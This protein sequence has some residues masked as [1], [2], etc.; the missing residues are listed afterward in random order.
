MWRCSS[1]GTGSR[2][3]TFLAISVAMLTLF[4]SAAPS[5]K[6]TITNYTV[7]IVTGGLP[8]GSGCA[9]GTGLLT[10]NSTL[11][12]LEFTSLSGSGCYFGE[13]TTGT[14]SPGEYATY[15]EGPGTCTASCSDLG[16]FTLPA[17][18]GDSIQFVG[19]NI[20][21]CS[22]SSSPNTSHCTQ[23]AGGFN[24]IFNVSSVTGGFFDATSANPN[25]IDTGSSGNNAPVKVEFD[26][27]V[28]T[29]EPASYLLFGS[30]LLCLGAIFRK[31]LGRGRAV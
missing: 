30:G 28:L 14:P 1:N 8:A 25:I 4:C 23:S 27:A 20:G 19:S 13:V 29:P 2:A 11:N 3:L 26:D 12:T 18:A 15:G 7:N 24:F 17:G 31:K 10:I 21:A 6:A 5:A 9:S 22:S 16:N